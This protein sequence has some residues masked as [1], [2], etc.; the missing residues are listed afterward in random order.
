MIAWWA[1]VTVTP[2][3]SR[4]KVLRNGTS[5]ALNTKIPAGGQ[6]LPTSTFGLR[7]LWKKAQKKDKKKNT[8]DTINN[9]MPQRSPKLT[10][11]VWNPWEAPSI[12]TS[13]HQLNAVKIRVASLK[14]IR[15][16]LFQ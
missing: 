1:Q 2:E 5:K 7:L 11:E 8:S 6:F 9:T 15:V 10:N 4:T 14:P 3:L 16:R 13:F 12:V